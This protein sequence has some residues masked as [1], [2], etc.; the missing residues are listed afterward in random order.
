MV[1]K[2]VTRIKIEIQ[3]RKQS[4]R[5]RFIFA[6]FFDTENDCIIKDR[7]KSAELNLDG[8]S[9]ITEPT[10][11]D[12]VETLS[13]GRY[14]LFQFIHSNCDGFWIVG[15][16]PQTRFE[17]H[18]SH[19]WFAIYGDDEYNTSSDDGLATYMNGVVSGRIKQPHIIY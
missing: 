3:C 16:T 13:F 8:D 6:N 1:A 17:M 2:K 5:R 18:K 19:N 9:L 14:V 10:I 12:K 11:N 7:E 4:R 15:L